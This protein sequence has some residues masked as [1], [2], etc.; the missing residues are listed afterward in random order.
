MLAKDYLQQVEKLDIM[1]NN[2]LAEKRQW[3]DMALSITANIGG[4]RVMTSGGA[5]SKMADAV[6]K[7]VDIEAEIDRLVEEFVDKKKEIVRVIE[8]VDSPIEYDILHKR[9]IQKMSLTDIAE[10]YGRE[11]TWATTTHGRALQSLQKI[12]DKNESL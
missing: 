11:Y 9:Y 7:C 2:K 1:I 6:A 3:L 8:T 10:R 4:D 5:Q 12:L